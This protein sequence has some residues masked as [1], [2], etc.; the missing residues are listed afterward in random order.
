MKRTAHSTLVATTIM[1][2]IA[3]AAALSAQGDFGP[4]RV[5][6]QAEQ[7][8]RATQRLAESSLQDL[9]RG[10]SGDRS[11]VSNA[12]LAQ[13]L[14]GIATVLLE[15][16]RY[17]RPSADIRE[18]VTQLSN[19]S[20]QAPLSSSQPWRPVQNAIADLERAV[21]RGGGAL[22][23]GAERPVIGRVQW[24]GVV[25]DRV[26]LVIRGRTIDQ[27]TISGTGQPAGTFTFTSPLPTTSVEVDAAKLSG[28]GTVRV[29]QQPAR[30]NDF[31]A[32]IEIVD[33]GGG[34]HEYRL[35]IVWR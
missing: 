17:N 13:H 6:P 18:A 7:L 35:E 33:D 27:Q 34:A 30:A 19:L 32:V 3:G 11:A 9:A 22:P 23:S 1:L 15:L 12:I 5:G 31:T 10:D 8:K 29:L 20:R 4:Q 26:R 16:I 21:V 14:D 28:R 24:R 2:A 25:D